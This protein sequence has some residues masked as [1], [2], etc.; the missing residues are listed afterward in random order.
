MLGWFKHVYVLHWM[1]F[2]LLAATWLSGYIIHANVKSPLAVL[3]YGA[4]IFAAVAFIAVGMFYLHPDNK[5][6]TSPLHPSAQTN[7]VKITH[8]G[9][10]YILRTQPVIGI[11]IFFVPDSDF[12]FGKQGSFWFNHVYNDNFAHMVH[13]MLF[14]LIVLLGMVNFVLMMNKRRKRR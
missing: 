10:Y 13:A 2:A 4:H 12:G 7:V 6:T 5:A 1:P 8:R 9:I 3:Y 11:L 14:Y